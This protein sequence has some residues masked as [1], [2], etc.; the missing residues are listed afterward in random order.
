MHS[1]ETDTIAT[2]AP[3]RTA[4]SG[5]VYAVRSEEYGKWCV[6]QVVAV[7]DDKCGLITLDWFE[8]I[9]PTSEQLPSLRLLYRQA[10]S[11]NH[12]TKPFYARGTLV[13]AAFDYIGTQPPL[14]N[15]PISAYSWWPTSF[16]EVAF[17]YCWTTYP[18]HERLR[19]KQS[20][21]SRDPVL[22]NGVEMRPD[23]W[24][25]H[26]NFLKTLTDWHELDT[27]GCL[28]EI[29]YEG[30]N[31]GLLD[32]VGSRQLIGTLLWQH[33]G[34]AALDFRQTRLR[35]LSLSAD[36]LRTVYVNDELNELILCGPVSD[37]IAIIH[38]KQ[39]KGLTLSLHKPGSSSLLP[40]RLAALSGFSASSVDRINARL[41]AQHYPN[42][43]SLSLFGSP[44]TI[45]HFSVLGALEHL[46]H[47]QLNNMFGYGAK[48]FPT[49]AQ[50]P[51]LD[52]LWASSLPADA[53]KFIRKEY[54]S[55]VAVVYIAQPRKPEWLE[56]NMDNPFR[57]WDGRDHIP[58]R[59]AKAAA[60][61]Y[62]KACT[63]LNRLE[64]NSS[65][66]TAIENILHTFVAVFNKID[67]SSSVIETIEREEV[68]EVFRTLVQ[69]LKPTTAEEKVYDTWFDS[70]RDF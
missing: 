34:K 60:D 16:Q 53:A 44:G 35:K 40:G 38:P 25:V 64:K 22:V 21:A 51:H 63:A 50:W 61:A 43:K 13:P 41:I 48:D 36:G 59:Q 37:D 28:T 9:K 70:W 26:G 18:E 30:E 46:S 52:N 65:D 5:D 2:T 20:K 15:E 66:Q 24:R 62:K 42:L 8:D 39:G 6:Y 67:A 56:A 68:Y 33:H 14:V 29:D 54:L 27:L 3:R 69:K 45:E 1:S 4:K 57:D 55:H 12:I 32:Y 47:L 11:W 17:E 58:A 10:F 7:E 49:R 19:Y 31:D 23:N